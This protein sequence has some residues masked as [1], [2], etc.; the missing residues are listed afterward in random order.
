MRDCMEV[1][2]N[3]DVC[4]VRAFLTLRVCLQ[5]EALPTEFSPW[6]SWSVRRLRRL[7]PRRLCASPKSG[8][9]VDGQSEYAASA[10]RSEGRA[11]DCISK[12]KEARAL[13]AELWVEVGSE[14]PSNPREGSIH[15]RCASA[16]TGAQRR[17]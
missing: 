3:G 4:E 9:E 14:L 11:G 16:V 6:G 2:G 12:A 8:S 5:V 15:G 1:V 7:R 13:G 10:Q 17:Q